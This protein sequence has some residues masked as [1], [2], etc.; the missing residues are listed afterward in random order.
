LGGVSH[1][2][3][4]ALAAVRTRIE[5]LGLEIAEERA[6]LIRWLM[7]GGIALLLLAIGLLTALVLLALSFWEQRL[8]L[9]GCLALALLSSG[10]FLAARVLREARQQVHPFHSSVTELAEDIRQLK[11]A[12]APPADVHPD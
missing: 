8:W 2:A 4:T 12:A 6:R 5:L 7:W 3:A 1:L 9:L 10:G 11:A